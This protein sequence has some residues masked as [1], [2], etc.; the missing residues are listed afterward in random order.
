MSL[1][2]DDLFIDKEIGQEGVWVDF[3]NGS[4]LKIASTESPK[5][6]AMMAKL[7]RAHKLQLDDSND[8]QH[9]L[10]QQI[11]SE[12]LSKCVLLD[13]DKISIGDQEHVQYNPEIGKKALLSSPKL[14]DFV[15]DQANSTNIFK[16]K[17]LD[18]A[19]KSSSG[20]SSGDVVSML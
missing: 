4:R 17:V 11:T 13:W 12:A 9:E 1:Q 20:N 14:R 8:D 15:L 10:V 18:E 16:K 3:F 19:K 7:A 5:Y 6:K 2:L